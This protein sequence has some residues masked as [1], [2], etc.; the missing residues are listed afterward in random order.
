MSISLS[1]EFERLVQGKIALGTYKTEDEV[2]RA[3]FQALEAQEETLAA[4]AE[5]YADFQ[6]GRC[7]DWDVADAEFRKLHN[8]LPRP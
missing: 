1:P 3:A 8:I 2:L 4:I 6:A 5:G 7:E